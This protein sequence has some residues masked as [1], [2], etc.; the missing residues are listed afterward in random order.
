MPL[1]TLKPWF[2]KLSQLPDMPAVH[3]LFSDQTSEGRI[4]LHNLKR[5]FEQVQ[6]SGADTLLIGEAPGYQGT[7]RTGLPFCSEFIMLGPKNKHGLFGGPDNGYARVY[8]D[9]R[10]WKEPSAT[11]VQRTIDELD[12][13][14]YIWATFPLHPHKPG[15]DLSNRAPNAAEIALGAELLRELIAILR[16]KQVIAVGNVAEK[17]LIGLDIP[18]V[19]VRHPSHGGAT[20]FREQLLELL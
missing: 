13:L 12:R 9:E 16:P 10:V 1:K 3:N 17:C 18:T 5:Y 4:R 19:K 2:L 6:A 14:P 15:I 11:V 7:Y 8:D 20:Q